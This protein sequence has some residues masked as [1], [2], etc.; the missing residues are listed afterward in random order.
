MSEEIKPDKDI[1][2][3]FIRLSKPIL[4]YL[5]LPLSGVYNDINNYLRLVDRTPTW[6]VYKLCCKYDIQQMYKNDG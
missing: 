5:D 4:N 2:I 1:D 3:K 6:N